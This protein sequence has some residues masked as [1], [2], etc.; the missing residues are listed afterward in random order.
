[1]AF[2]FIMKSI[3]IDKVRPVW[4]VWTAGGLFLILDYT[5]NIFYE[6]YFNY[7]ILTSIVIICVILS[8][9]VYIQNQK[10]ALDD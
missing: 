7:F 9:F 3:F 4:P 2:T 8:A 5:A 6:G 10:I 1:M